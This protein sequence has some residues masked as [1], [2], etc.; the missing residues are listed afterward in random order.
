MID[1]WHRLGA[2]AQLEQIRRLEDTCRRQHE[3]LDRLTADRERQV[4]LIEEQS[5]LLQAIQGVYEQRLEDAAVQSFRLDHE[6]IELRQRL[7][8]L[9]AQLAMTSGAASAGPLPC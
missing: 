9:E 2:K 3:L 4:A 5:A 7:R 1:P 8:E 6:N